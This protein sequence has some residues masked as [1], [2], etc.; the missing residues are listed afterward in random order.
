MAKP[1]HTQHIRIKSAQNPR[2][3]TKKDDDRAKARREAEALLE[4]L[5]LEKEIKELW[6]K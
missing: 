3:P 5:N 6:A 2:K 4:K 1:D